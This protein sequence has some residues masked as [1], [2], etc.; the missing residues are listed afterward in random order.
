MRKEGVVDV[1]GLFDGCTGKEI[2]VML[3]LNNSR[4]NADGYYKMGE[5]IVR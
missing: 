2:P 3:V 4:R 5:I 1:H